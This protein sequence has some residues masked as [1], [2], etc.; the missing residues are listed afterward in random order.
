MEERFADTPRLLI[1]MDGTLARFERVDTLERLYEKGYFLNLE[2]M[3]NVVAAV[4]LFAAKNP[5]VPVYILSCVLEDSKY[6]LEEK[7]E[8]LDRYLPEVSPEYRIFPPC[9][10][11]KLSYVPDGI[12]ADDYQAAKR[13][14]PHQRDVAGKYAALRQTG[15]AA[16]GRYR[17]CYGGKADP[18]QEAVPAILKREKASRAKAVE[19]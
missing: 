14:Q 15:R 19:H 18:G 10:E 7:Q 17:I 8:W 1:D 6:A 9:G 3:R 12:R 13:N 5:Q 16:C 4:K 2:P 11:N